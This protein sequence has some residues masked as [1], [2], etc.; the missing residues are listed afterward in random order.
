MTAMARNVEIKAR[1]VAP[2][3]VERRAADLADAGPEE[4][5]QEDIFFH[6]RRG[7]LKLRVFGPRR[8]E[9][10]Y[11]ER[12]DRRGPKLSSYVRV[13]LA[14]PA[15]MRAAL[16]KALGVW[17]IVRKRRRVYLARNTRIHLDEVEG[18]GKFLELEV[19]LS[20]GQT[21]RQGQRTAERLMYRLGIHKKD[22]ISGAYLD[23][24]L[25]RRQAKRRTG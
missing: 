12:I 2:D 17:G 10:I 9:L 1:L 18:L 20:G 16:S 22:L 5:H 13:A 15:E 3:T 21:P 23:L 4:L 11:Y 6:T 19:V 7:R 8:G 24:L 14:H 25:S